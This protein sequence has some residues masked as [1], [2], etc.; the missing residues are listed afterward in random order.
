ML[1]GPRVVRGAL[2]RGV[3]P[4]RVY[5]GP[6]ADRAFGPLVERLVAA[7]APVAELREGVL[8]R[9]ADARTPQPVLAVA[10]RPEVALAELPDDG[11][12]VV[13]AGV[14]DPGNA[15]A[16]V[17]SA[18]AAGA[19]GVVFAG[20]VDPFGPRAVRASAGA[21]FGVRVVEADDPVEVLEALG[22]RG[23][24]RLGT[25][26]RGGSAPEAT[27]LTAPV[28]V[29]LGSEGRGLDPAVTGLLDGAVTIPM[30]GA[31]ESLNVAVAAAVVAFEAARQRRGGGAPE[32][33]RP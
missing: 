22:A 27:D 7:G 33:A 30:A 20:P 4:T 18:E 10:A 26:A 15:G 1:E 31:A 12:V 8:E 25:L 19:A 17:R 9:V 23:R 14:Q 5:L 24:R 3:V 32:G 11:L 13:V 28:A 16:I 2:D 29:V 6:R 21:V